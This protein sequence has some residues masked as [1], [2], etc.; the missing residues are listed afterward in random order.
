M[1]KKSYVVIPAIVIFIVSIAYFVVN[2]YNILTYS[3]ESSKDV[4]QKQQKVQAELSIMY[5]AVRERTLIL[6]QMNTVDDAFDMDD[7]RQVMRDNAEKFLLAREAMKNYDVPDSEEWRQLDERLRELSARGVVLKNRVADL[8][9]D[10]NRTLALELLV[11]ESMPVQVAL[12]ST[13]ESMKRI[14]EGKVNYTINK[15][16]HE[17]L[18]ARN[19]FQIVGAIL[20]LL[21]L[22]IFVAI[23][24]FLVRGE[25]NLRGLLAHREIQYK[26]IVDTV[27]DGIIT[28]NSK[29][30]ISSFNRE[31]EKIFDY[32]SGE[33]RGRNIHQLI[34]RNDF[35]RLEEYIKK[36]NTGRVLPGTGFTGRKKD[37]SR[38]DLHLSLSDTGIAGEQCLSGIVRDISEEKAN[39]NILLRYREIFSRSDDALAFIDMHHFYKVVN[40]KYLR[41]F[42]KTSEDVID[43]TVSEVIGESLF[44][45]F[46]RFHQQCILNDEVVSLN[47]WVE[48]PSGYYYL[49]ISYTPYHDDAGVIVG[50][51]V[52]I[53]DIT[54]QK[55]AE[56]EYFKSSK[57]E[58]V[59]V[60]A[61]GIAHD[62]NNLLGGILGNIEMAMRSLDDPEKV[63]RF[64]QTSHKAGGRAADLTQQ[65]LTF[66]KGGEPVKE[67][68]SVAGLLQDTMEFCLHGSSIQRHFDCATD[69]WNIYA[70]SGQI[71]QVVQNIVINAKQAMPEGGDIFVSCENVSRFS[72]ELH[73][74]ARNNCDFVK[75][76]IRDSGKGMSEAVQNSI[77]DPYFTTREKGSGLGLALSYSIISKHDGFIS[78]ESTPGIGSCFTIYI[79]AS[80]HPVIELDGEEVVIMK[81]DH[82]LRVMV[83]DD[84]EM[85]REIA[86]AMLEELGY[87]VVHAV[88]GEEALQQYQQSK[89]KPEDKI[90]LI[91][92]DLTILGGMGGKET[93]KAILAID[94]DV[95][96]IVSSGYSNDPVM[97]NYLEYGFKA[98]VSKPYNIDELGM[99]IQHC[100]QA[101]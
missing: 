16:N 80:T 20:L 97:A 85:I 90:D 63:M 69:I 67:H 11:N 60:L 64:L 33:I 47:Q 12:L 42:N 74:L 6:L 14:S 94:P 95:L 4:I 57:L 78:V 13:L 86:E 28:M 37:G 76:Q 10:G 48:T 35:K 7:L 92:M 93:I 87:Q 23:V 29:G 75:I 79:P 51:A 8:F 72:P 70:D 52:A 77:F 65:L 39:Y 40:D 9:V 54:E 50:V 55:K 68:V 2:G 101:A 5:L 98:A 58:S 83:M 31:A 45:T 88:N 15:L 49:S 1:M 44:Y 38:I 84:D 18:I 96:A 66:S 27:K 81:S 41:L 46:E 59:G 99:A 17:F 89:D 24:Y 61:G 34:D 30:K 62:F 100:L 91:I 25:D 73:L 71:S 36:I 53:R 3:F 43:F 32:S 26:I 19:H 22:V 82:S 21:V 56:D